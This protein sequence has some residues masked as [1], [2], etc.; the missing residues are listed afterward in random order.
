MQN[1]RML[2]RMMT[3]RRM[4]QRLPPPSPVSS[5]S[6]LKQ[7]HQ[8]RLNQSLQ[9]SKLFVNVRKLCI[10]ECGRKTVLSLFD[11][12]MVPMRYVEVETS[13]S[14]SSSSLTS[15]TSLLPNLKEL[16]LQRNHLTSEDVS[17]LFRRR[18]LQHQNV[19]GGTAAA[20]TDQLES[21]N[22]L[23]NSIDTLDFVQQSLNQVDDYSH[24]GGDGSSN[25]V[26][27]GLRRLKQIILSGNPVMD[28][29][30]PTTEKNRDD[31]TTQMDWSV[32]DD[33][34]DDDHTVTS[35]STSSSTATGSSRSLMELSSSLLSST[36]PFHGIFRIDGLSVEQINVVKLLQIAPQLHFFGYASPTSNFYSK[37]AQHL[38]N[39]NKSGGRLLMPLPPIMLSD[40]RSIKTAEC[41]PTMTKVPIG[42]WPYVF[43]RSNRMYNLMLDDSENAKTKDTTIAKTSCFT[44]SRNLSATRNADALYFLLRHGSSF[45]G[46]EAL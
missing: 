25:G 13:R 46:R 34:D 26:M 24:C 31:S 3:R 2:A 1:K 12:L 35:S 18:L 17:I 19:V 22:L 32:S 36:I 27:L 5:S 33:E 14:G 41:Q 10:V 40:I 45:A 28:R 4:T 38:I 8:R 37:E 15:A 11:A 9:L 21:I 20:A 6:C 29:K 44:D 16:H 42:I 43:A 30:E 39:I 7:L 23:G